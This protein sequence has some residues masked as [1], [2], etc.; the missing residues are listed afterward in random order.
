MRVD[1]IFDFEDGKIGEGT[2]GVVYKAIKRN[3][4]SIFGFLHCDD[5]RVWALK[6]IK[7]TTTSGIS[8]SSCRE[9]AVSTPSEF[10]ED[11]KGVRSSQHHTR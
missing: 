7:G 10:N 2:Y 11:F 6:K 8:I 5:L 4:F 1:E 3:R 9:I